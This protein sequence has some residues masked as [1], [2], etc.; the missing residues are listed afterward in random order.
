[1]SDNHFLF[2]RKS[3][4]KRVPIVRTGETD[5]SHK[6]MARMQD[7]PGAVGST[8]VYCQKVEGH[9]GKHAG[10]HGEGL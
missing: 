2:R 10:P 9:S 5:R 1:M 6:C 8:S 3:A 7:F 4:V